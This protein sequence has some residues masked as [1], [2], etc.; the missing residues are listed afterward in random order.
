M[1]LVVLFKKS[2]G[3]PLKISD[4]QRRKQERVEFYNKY[5]YKNKLRVC[6]CCNGSGYYDNTD[7]WGKVPKCGN[8]R[9]TG[10]QRER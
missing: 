4:Y 9:G 2:M 5:V 8:C 1:K 7:K 3:Y 6:G 10:K